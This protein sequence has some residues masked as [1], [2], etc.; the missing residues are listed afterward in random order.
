[1]T[2]KKIIYQLIPQNIRVILKR[3]YYIKLCPPFVQLSNYIYYGRS[4]M[5]D[6]INIET[7]SYCNLRCKC[8]PNSIY[9]RGLL[10]NRKLMDIK[11]F[12]KII[13]ELSE[14]RYR[15]G[16]AMQYYG[17]PLSDLRMPELVKYAHDKCPHARVTINSNGFLLTIPLYLKLVENG[18]E[19]LFISQ[20]TNKIQP[21]YKI[22]MDYLKTHPGVPNRVSYRVFNGEEGSDAMYNRGGDIKLAKLPDL[23]SCQYPK[24]VM[25]INVDGNI[26]LCGQDYHA[27]CTFGNAKDQTLEQIWDSKSFKKMR[28][29]LD[30]NK[31]YL[32]ICKKC[33]G[34]IR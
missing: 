6:V 20:Y 26:V 7:T 19:N 3:I 25:H 30:H 18:L 15:G 5:F 11:I 34:E 12:K 9:P 1:M 17:E 10:V 14:L 23:P 24:K 27:V 31:F 4:S 29:D 28:K 13:D 33:I 32:E 21:N 22:L 16:I 2:F 8:C